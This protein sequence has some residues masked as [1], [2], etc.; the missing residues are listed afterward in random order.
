MEAAERFKSRDSGPPTKTHKLT[1]ID[2]DYS[3]LRRGLA[4]ARTETA[5][6]RDSIQPAMCDCRGPSSLEPVGPTPPVW[7]GLLTDLMPP[8]DTA[9]YV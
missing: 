4:V 2:V 9:G 1:H 3:S 8:A 5:I 6:D 7:T